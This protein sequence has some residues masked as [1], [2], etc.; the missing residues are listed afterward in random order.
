M[1]LRYTESFVK[2]EMIFKKVQAR[3]DQRAIFIL[4]DA[5]QSSL[6]F[7]TRFL[8]SFQHPKSKVSETIIL[9]C[10]TKASITYSPVT[11]PN[12]VRRFGFFGSTD[13]IFAKRFLWTKPAHT[14]PY[15]LAV[16]FDQIHPLPIWYLLI[17][18]FD[19]I[20]PVLVS[21]IAYSL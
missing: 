15:G 20:R 2:K 14:I 21:P 4:R 9:Y 12:C 8:R 11:N 19:H 3:V 1:M 6:F 5:R 17:G 18:C 7:L 16:K 13:F 10:G